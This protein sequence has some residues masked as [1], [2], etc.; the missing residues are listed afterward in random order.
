M[1]VVGSNSSGGSIRSPAAIYVVCIAIGL[2]SGLGASL[3]SK[4]LHMAESLFYTD[5]IGGHLSASFLDWPHEFNVLLLVALAAGGLVNG[6][7]AH[8]F[9][10]EIRGSGVDF[11]IER[12]HHHEGHMRGRV[13]ILKSIATVFTLATGGSAGKEGPAAQIGAGLSSL[14]SNRLKIGPRARRTLLLAGV[15]AGLGA[16]FHAPLA[17]ALTAVEMLYKED[18]ESDAIVPCII[19]SIVAYLVSSSFT[20]GGP[21]YSVNELHFQLSNV[22]AYILLGLVCFAAGFVFIRTYN[23]TSRAF[24]RL[25]VHPILKPVIG[26]VC[27]FFVALAVPR[28]TG[29][30][31]EVLQTLFDR[32]FKFEHAE[33]VRI[34]IFF[35]VLAFAKIIA[36]SF[37]VGSGSAGGLYG[38]SLLIGAS[39]GLAVAALQK[40]I[41][42]QLEVS[43]VSFALVGMGAFYS[44][45][46]SAPI[47]AII[48]VCELVGNYV[49]LPPLMLVSIL[50]LVLSHKWSIYANQ[51]T[52]RFGSPAHH[53]DMRT[54]LLERIT[55]QTSGIALRNIAVVTA[56]ITFARL[57]AAAEQVHATD[58]VVRDKHSYAGMISLK[59]AQATRHRE[60]IERF[61][62]DTVPSLSPAESL[63]NALKL[64]VEKDVDKAPVVL[65][66]E[67]LG[68]V[69]YRDIVDYYFKHV[70]KN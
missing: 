26:A 70:Q 44:G 56:G 57:K 8:Y 10:P 37:T 24:T 54:D 59:H 47:A 35:A 12:F 60:R 7:L 53:W 6:I 42:P 30:S 51:V 19:A 18:L 68:Y 4:V 40:I 66:G 9:G 25:P 33:P 38:P 55:I 50:A 34:L 27:V 3:F 20:G 22:P 11:V 13:A 17:G 58:F 69:R 45:I 49:L 1:T 21:L 5:Y 23:L 28:I 14:I 36:T 62:D 64:M 2:V 32:E 29:S 39:L 65:N 48:F 41:L 52:N 46:A 15:A 63:S 61:V 16:I 67:L 31:S 43:Y